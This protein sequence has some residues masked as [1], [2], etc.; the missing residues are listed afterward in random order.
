MAKI[1]YSVKSLGL[2]QGV[3][4]EMILNED[5]E[6]YE[7]GIKL[8]EFAYKQGDNFFFTGLRDMGLFGAKRIN[9]Q[10]V[11]TKGIKVV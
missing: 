3:Q 5:P 4:C 6:K 1:E 11:Y 7:N 8:V 2:K 9:N 10:F